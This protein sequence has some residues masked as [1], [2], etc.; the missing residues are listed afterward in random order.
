[1]VLAQH[2]PD[3]SAVTRVEPGEFYRS[4]TRIGMAADTSFVIPPAWQGVMPRGSRTL[5]LESPKKPGIGLAAVIQDATPE[6]L[7]DH[8]NEPQVI[9]EGYVLHPVGSAKR[10]NTHIT[11]S[12]HSGENVGR[13]LAFFGPFESGIG[14]LYLFTGPKEETDYYESLLEQM[15]VS[16]R[17]SAARPN[18][19]DGREGT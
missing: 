16:T 19:S 15:A 14:I 12:Y 9:E 18:S 4:G 6:E 5:Y 8:L 17:F 11:A 2:Q 1:M 7:E 3:E 10:T 13:A